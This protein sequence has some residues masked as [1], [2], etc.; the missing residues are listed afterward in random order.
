MKL[1]IKSAAC[2]LAAIAVANTNAAAQPSAGL[3]DAV[4]S[5]VRDRLVNPNGALI[6]TDGAFYRASA[7]INGQNWTGWAMDIRLNAK[8]A[9]GK[10]T[11]FHRRAVLVGPQGPVALKVDVK[12]FK[13]LDE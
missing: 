10:R 11:G 13:K 6:R 7:V 3:E 12:K 1:I 8:V 2:A 5:Y 9:P 4:K